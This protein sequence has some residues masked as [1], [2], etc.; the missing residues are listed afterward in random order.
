MRK[1]YKIDWDTYL[2][3]ANVDIPFSQRRVWFKDARGYV[4]TRVGPDYRLV[5]TVEYANHPQ[6]RAHRD[7]RIT[8]WIVC[9]PSILVA[10]GILPLS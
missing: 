2:T 8:T 1:A 6:L 9:H 3:Y 4:D 5:L 7:G 10:K